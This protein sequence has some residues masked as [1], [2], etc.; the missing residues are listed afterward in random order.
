MTIYQELFQHKKYFIYT[1]IF[2]LVM[3]FNYPSNQAEWVKWEHG[4]RVF[5]F[6]IFFKL[7]WGYF[8][9]FNLYINGSGPG[10][11]FCKTRTRFRFL[12]KEIH[13]RPYNLSSQVKSHPLGSSRARYPRVRYKL[14][15]LAARV[16]NE[17]TLS[18]WS[19]DTHLICGF[20]HSILPSFIPNPPKWS[21]FKTWFP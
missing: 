8:S 1:I 5:F 4:V 17:N 16:E 20:F 19:S 3:E 18:S 7:I 9:I 12:K 6:L 11:G 21:L 14:P 15:S 13:T 2:T 10:L